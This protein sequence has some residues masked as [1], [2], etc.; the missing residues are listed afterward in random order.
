MDAVVLD[1]ELNVASFLIFNLKLLHIEVDIRVRPDVRG[2]LVATAV[3]QP[4]GAAE[5]LGRTDAGGRKA[6]REAGGGG[7]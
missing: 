7:L 2:R 1:V 4:L 6:E 3:V 5:A